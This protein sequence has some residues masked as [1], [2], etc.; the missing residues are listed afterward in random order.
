MDTVA[1]KTEDYYDIAGSANTVQSN[2]NNYKKS[3]DTLVSSNTNSIKSLN[4]R[5]TNLENAE[6][7]TISLD[8]INNLFI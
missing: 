6:P 2:L 7:D 4:T 1:Y 3:N 8:E 5:I